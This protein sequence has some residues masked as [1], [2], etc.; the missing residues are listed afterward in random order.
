ML[1]LSVHTPREPPRNY[2][3]VP[4]ACVPFDNSRFILEEAIYLVARYFP[5]LRE[6]RIVVIPPRYQF[7]YFARIGRVGSVGVFPRG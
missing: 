1:V 3:I 5:N 7:A 2:K 6:V 4:F